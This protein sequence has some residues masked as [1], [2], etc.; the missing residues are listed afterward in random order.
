MFHSL[1]NCAIIPEK[2]ET[3]KVKKI[4][5]YCSQ[6]KVQYDDS[7]FFC[8]EDGQP[9]KS[10][11]GAIQ[12]NPTTFEQTLVL[13]ADEKTLTLPAQNNLSG[14]KSLTLPSEIP[15]EQKQVLT[16][17]W[18]PSSTAKTNEELILSNYAESNENNGK[19]KFIIGGLLGGLAL[20]GAAIGGWW[21]LKAP[22]DEVAVANI[23]KQQQN[24]NNNLGLSNAN[25]SN[26]FGETNSAALNSE[27]N[28]NSN[29]STPKTSPSPTKDKKESPTPT[30]S[31]TPEP[32]PDAQPT[33]TPKTPTPTVTPTPAPTRKPP[34]IVS[35]GVLNG[36]AVNLVKPPYP[37][38]AK[39]V[40]AGG[41]VSVQVLIDEDGN[42]VR[43]SAVSGHALLRAA[44][45][46]AARA[47]KFSPTMISGQPVKV[48]GVIVYNFT[49]Q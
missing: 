36:K 45:E 34:N 37:P 29:K 21:L 35:G 17:A 9:L 49:A 47:S 38:A 46:S 20:F 30:S 3:N 15:T 48:T 40:R 41:A 1:Q 5:K 44:A 14:E 18:K 31:Q 24:P 8:L 6:C 2:L 23:N 13:P 42:V 4:M 22:S 7:M 43:A 11:D 10:T 12:S 28:T 39:A 16:E 33:L 26:A 27:P 32:T 19:G 25:L